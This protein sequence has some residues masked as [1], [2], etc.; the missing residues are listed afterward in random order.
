[1]QV[2]RLQK[3]R[4][5]W[6]NNSPKGGDLRNR[7]MA[8]APSSLPS[9]MRNSLS[10]PARDRTQQGNLIFDPVSPALGQEGQGGK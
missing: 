7:H 9:Q 5:V 3:L 4:T 2:S 6:F 1:M 8:S 10:V